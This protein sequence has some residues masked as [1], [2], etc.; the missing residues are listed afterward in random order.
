MSS[1]TPVEQRD[2]ERL[3]EMSLGYVLN[4]TDRTFSE[5]LLD[6]VGLNLDDRKYSVFGGS[7]AKRLRTFW[8]VDGDEVVGRALDALVQYRETDDR[9][10]PPEPALLA[11]C[12]G[13]TARLL[14]GG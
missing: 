6:S 13:A 2:F 9:R 3:F 14:A 1:L 8:R 10:P 4:F 7:K 12:K 5:F 11:R